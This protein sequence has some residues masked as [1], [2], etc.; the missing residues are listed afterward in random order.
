MIFEDLRFLTDENIDSALVSLLRELG[1]DVLDIK[2]EGFFRLPDIRILEMALTQQRVV[3]TQDSDFGTLVFRDK[4]PFWGIIY[5]RPGHDLPA[6]HQQ[7][8]LA[9]LKANLD[10]TIPFVLIAENNGEMIR[11]RLRN[12]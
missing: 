7:S 3:I 5:L 1:F 4:N 12:I 9:L 6:I 2:E 10:F 11:I 8:M